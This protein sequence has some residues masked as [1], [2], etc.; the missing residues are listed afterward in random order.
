[1]ARPTY[2]A[3]LSPVGEATFPCFITTPD[4]QYNPGGEF[5][6]D[7]SVPFEEAQGVIATLEGALDSFIQTLSL[8]E[9]KALTP[10]PVYKEELT[11]PEIADDATKEEKK[12]IWDNW[13]GEPTGN[14]LIRF[15][16]K[17]NVTTK[18]GETF[19]QAPVVIDDSTGEDIEGA[20]FGGSIIRVKAQ[21][22]PYTNSAAGTVGVTLRMRSVFVIEQVGGDV[23]EGSGEDFWRTKNVA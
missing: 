5:K 4:T 7:L 22:V 13:L 18:K 9:Q 11:R 23:P 19:T 17:N 16:L 20:V 8:R 1:M 15:K 3:F 14:V 12:A 6:V 10:V 2:T 21:A